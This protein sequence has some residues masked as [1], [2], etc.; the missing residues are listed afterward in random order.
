MQRTLHMR[1]ETEREREREK[2]RESKNT[3]ETLIRILMNV[4]MIKNSYEYITN[5]E[6]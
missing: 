3:D 6:F 2:E 4:Y 1:I 5:K